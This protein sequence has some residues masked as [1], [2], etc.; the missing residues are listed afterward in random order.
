M[1]GSIEPFRGFPAA[2][3][4]FLRD[5]AN[6][7]NKPWFEAHKTIYLT[8]VQAP[9]VALVADLGARLQ[10]RFPDIR[11]DTRTN[12]AG[13]LMR[14]HRDTRFSADKSPY[15]TNVAMMFAS[16]TAKKM[17]APG[18]GLQLTPERVELIA[19]VFGF[20]P[21]ALEVYRA[22]VLDNALGTQLEHAVAEVQRAGDYPIAGEGY[23][24]VPAGLPADHPRAQ[25]LKYKGLHVFA[26]SIDLAVAQTPALID[27]A[28]DR[29][30]AMAPVQQWL[31]QALAEVQ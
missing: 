28:L 2:G 27:A 3:I 16:G 30:T 26:P 11:Y 17:A 13:S 18:F 9:A 7:N 20:T 14:M 15:K 1:S 31:V 5:L 12:G 29:F 21:D 19:G 25:W 22:A 10:A 4:Q 8:D 23:K 24:R 6:N